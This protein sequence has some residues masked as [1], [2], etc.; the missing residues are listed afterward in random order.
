MAATKD[1]IPAECHHFAPAAAV[2]T[3]IASYFTEDLLACGV[4]EGGVV[5]AGEDVLKLS[6][7]AESLLAYERASQTS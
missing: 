1:A 3:E 2:A 6:C 5:A 4:H 7:L